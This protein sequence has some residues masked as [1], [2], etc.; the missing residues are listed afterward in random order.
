[1]MPSP[2][3]SCWSALAVPGQLSTSSGM[4]SPSLSTFSPIGVGVGSAP[5]MFARTVSDEAMP[6]VFAT[7][8]SNSYLPGDDGVNVAKLLEGEPSDTA[9][10]ARS[11]QP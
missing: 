1:P 3:E 6:L 5:S 2:S 11:N 7:I 8:R 9:G 10:P 4:L